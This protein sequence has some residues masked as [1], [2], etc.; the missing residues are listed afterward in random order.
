MNTRQQSDLVVIAPAKLNL[1][2]NI[3]HKREDGFH[4]IDSLMQAIDL[5]DT[6]RISAAQSDQIQLRIAQT[7]PSCAKADVIPVDGRNLI[8]KAANLLQ[9]VTGCELG[10]NILLHKRIPSQA[11]LG[12]GSSDAASALIGLNQ[13]WSLGLSREQLSKIGAQL[14]S[15]IPFFVEGHPLAIATGRGEIL[16]PAAAVPLHFVI[17]KPSSGLSTAA[18]YSGLAVSPFQHSAKDLA[19]A[20]PD[21]PSASI[22]SLMHN[23]LQ[24]RAESLNHDVVTALKALRS[25]YLTAEMLSGSGTACFGLC[26]NRSHALAVAG[27]LRHL[28]IG[29]VYVARSRV[30][31]L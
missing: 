15:D 31:Q 19:N 26:R 12:G 18:V 16:Q 23:S 21:S 13:F 29:S 27:R 30:S 17:V 11:G 6:L 25:Q 20:L 2:L 24:N 10:A 4:E 5:H 22:K 7:S 8:V 9:Q 1:F 3:L 28:R 14:G